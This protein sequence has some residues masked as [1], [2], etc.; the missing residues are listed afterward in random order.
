M[1]AIRATHEDIIDEDGE[2]LNVIVGTPEKGEQLSNQTFD[3]K[4]E[5]ALF[6]G[7]LPEEAETAFQADTQQPTLNF[8]R[9]MPPQNLARNADGDPILPNIRLDRALEYLLGDQLR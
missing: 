6:P 2:E 9:F 1:A 4:T 5:V 3:G 8:M 7:D